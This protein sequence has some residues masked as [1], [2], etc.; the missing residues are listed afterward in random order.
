MIFFLF[1]VV[2][3]KKAKLDE[4]IESLKE[5]QALLAEAQAKL[6][7]LNMYLQKL[8]KEYEEKLEQKEELNRKVGETIIQ[9]GQLSL[10]EKIL[11]L[12]KILFMVH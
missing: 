12:L 1:R 9:C 4:A 2:G 11:L 8:Q 10:Q 7:E 5:K 6:A 3:P